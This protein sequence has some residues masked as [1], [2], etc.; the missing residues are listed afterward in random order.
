MQTRT[1]HLATG[2]VSLL[3][4][5]STSFAAPLSNFAGT[6]ADVRSFCSGQDYFLLE[7][8]SYTLCTTPDTDVMCRDDNTCTSSDLTMALLAGF[9]DFDVA[10]VDHNR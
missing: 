6:R 2:L 4:L 8:G 3:M 1:L 10:S 9:Q 7:G 5:T